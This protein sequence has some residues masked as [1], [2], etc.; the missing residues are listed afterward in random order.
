ML[1]ERLIIAAGVVH[2]AI[3]SANFVAARLFDYRGNIE[4]LPRFMRDVFIVQNVFIVFVLVG[5]SLACFLFP[6]ELASGE[7]LGR[8]V[9]LFLGT[10]WLL[11]LGVQ[12]FFYDRE[13]RHEYRGFDIAFTAA[14]VYLS[15]VFLYAGSIS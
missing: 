7:P 1:L 9:S 11:R 13:K 3:A 5:F 2:L 8:G 14:F 12:L 15:S 6:S 10:F 4:K